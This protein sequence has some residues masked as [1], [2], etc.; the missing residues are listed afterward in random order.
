MTSYTARL[1]L[2]HKSGYALEYHWP[3]F[4]PETFINLGYIIHKP[5]R[6]A[7]EAESTAKSTTTGREMA[8]I[9]ICDTID[10]EDDS[11]GNIEEEISKI[12]LP[13]KRI[14]Y[15]QIILIEGVPGIG[16]TMLMME[17][18][19]LWANN[20][21]LENTKVLLLFFL[22]D[23]KINDFDSIKDMFHYLCQIEEHA[24]IYAKYFE[25]N[26]GKGLTILLDGFDENP[27][28]MQ[29]GTFFHKILIN[30]KIFAEACIIITSRPHVTTKLQNYVSYRV[31][32]IGFTKDRRC[33]FVQ[34]NLKEKA[35]DL[36]NYLEDHEIIDTL[37]YIPLNMSIVVSLSKLEV[38]LIDLPNNQTELTRQAVRMTVFHYLEELKLTESQ[39]QNDLEN[40]PKPFNEV[41]YYLTELAYN[42]MAKM[43]LTFTSNE[44]RK[45]CPVPINGNNI[46][47][48]TIT[49]GLGLIHVAQFTNE[50]Y[51]GTGLLS[52]FA[53]YSV[54]ELLAAWYIAFSH[55][56]Y[57]QQL[58]LTCSIRQGMQ[59]WLQFSFQLKVLKTRF[60]KGE[61]IDVWSFYIGLTGGNDF[62][63]KCFLTSNLF[64]CHMPYKSYP[65]LHRISSYMV[66]QEATP[67]DI[68]E[69]MDVVQWKKRD[70][71]NKLRA[72]LLYYYL[73]EAPESEVIQQFDAVVTKDM[74]DISEQVLDQKQDL[75]LLGNILSRPYL[76]KQWK[77]V[78][79][80]YCEIDDKKF[81]ILHD[82]LTRNDGRFKPKIEALLLS[83]NKLKS[84][85]G[86]IA[87]LACRQ[88]ILYLDL[89]NNVLENF[90]SLRRC[91]FLVTLD[92]SNNKLNNEKVAISLIALQFLRKLKYLKLKHNTIH[93]NQDVIDAIGLALCSCNSLE[94]LEL[95]GNDTEFIDKTTLLFSVIK[96]L[97][98]SRS[99]KHYYSKQTD[100]ASAFL[101]ILVHCNKINYQCDM[102]TLRNIIIQSEVIDISCNGLKTED[103]RCLGQ[104]L[105]LLINLKILIIT[106]NKISDDATESLSIGIILCPNLK[107]FKYDEN[108]F[109]ED[110]IM[111]FK[112]IRRLRMTS[113]RQMFKCPPPKIAALLFILNCI[114][115]NEEKVQSSDMVSTIGL[116]LEL[117][118]SHNKPTTL[119]HK[120]TSEDIK[121]LCAVLRWFKLLEV[122]D[123]SNNDI[124]VEAKTLLEMAMIQICT[125]NSIKLIGNPIFD[126][127]PSM[128][129]FDTIINV[130]ENQVQS[131][132]CNQDSPQDIG[133]HPIL[134]I[135]NCL[136][137]FKNP[138]CFKSFDNIT[139]VDV[140]SEA[141]HGVKVLENLTL[142]P[143]LKVLKIN[144]VPCV[145]D[146]GM[147]ELSKYVS[148]NKTLTTLDLSDC[149]LK[150]LEG[151]LNDGTSNRIPMEVLKLNNSN[152]TVKVLSKLFN[153]ITLTKLNQLELEGNCFGHEGIIIL[154]NKLRCQNDQANVT[155]TIL[156]LAGNQLTTNSAIIIVEMMAT[157]QVKH[158]NISNNDLGNILPHFK[159]F[160][161]TT[162][163]ELNI[164]ANN[165]Q[166]GSAGAF[167]KSLSYLNPCSSLKKLNISSNNIDKT[168]ENEIL[169]FFMKCSHFEEVICTGNPAENEINLAFHH[170]KNRCV[171]HISFK[172]HPILAQDLISNLAL[173]SN[174]QIG[175]LTTS[176]KVHINHVISIDFSHNY[177]KIDKDF[178]CLLQNCF[179]LE[180]LNLE[181]NDIT[182][183][184]FKYYLATGII[185]T[186]KLLL[187]KLQLSGNPCMVVDKLKN[188][189]ILQIIHALRSKSIHYRPPSFEQFLTV[190]ELVDRVNEKQNDIIKHISL[191]KH[192]DIGYSKQLSD[193][194]N[195]NQKL[196]SCDIK[197]ICKYL[198]YFKSLKSIGMTDNNIEKDATDDLAIAILKHS[199]IE[200]ILLKGN[201][202]YK[203]SKCNTLLDT[204]K[205]MRTCGKSYALKRGL[206]FESLEVLVTILQYINSIDDTI[207]YITDSIEQLNVSCFYQP[208]YKLQF[209]IEK[210]EE[211]SIALIC[212]LKLF[213]KLKVLNLS[214][215]YLTANGLQELSRFL[216][217]NNTLLELDISYNDIQVEGALIVLKSLDKNKP[218]TKLKLACNKITGEQCDEMATIICNLR[219]K[220]DVSGNK[221]TEN[222]KK[223]LGLK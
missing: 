222:S 219:I 127:K 99:N 38:Q 178:V 27:Q 177:M 162:L 24:E 54:Q 141:D 71:K 49:N 13:V 30:E 124:T 165:H 1:K 46:I 216:Q 94:V 21:I 131:I 175:A 87:N 166:T 110:S 58:P 168:A 7:E 100:K 120:L 85:S 10:Y 126:D 156:N 102:C 204:I 155:I 195:V 174:D 215:I 148:Q 201:P 212:H 57:F 211:M 98:N 19:R 185:F 42:A 199:N 41:F 84:C 86:A 109:S 11:D 106:K 149:N 217:N 213:S 18:R 203:T 79:L 112:M 2:R 108:L 208:Q 129:V 91:D 53:H 67:N 179:Q 93:G 5:K 145:T 73:Q 105:P 35:E 104:H 26:N 221:L 192:L 152:V 134:Y 28:A 9:H 161:I 116:I 198:K 218:L 200:E 52:N 95:D 172:Q 163:E 207:H 151:E 153:M 14:Q 64:S 121:K 25:R 56:S 196:Q 50:G 135:M 173:S 70:L 4:I 160:T 176:V 107:Q 81:K 138:T 77:S 186:S 61:Y 142:L 206:E 88:Q 159:N 40:L 43:K 97:R 180:A 33:E 113:P 123:V 136:S 191:I 182:N 187:S 220:A 130:R 55:R 23:P 214:R 114:N 69:L 158:L 188:E 205:K 31:E 147:N 68:P 157:Y 47:K 181:Y 137:Q 133:Y 39:N 17:I 74:L 111:I 193:S 75:H 184:A 154:H 12:F 29:S 65:R 63:F 209:G 32:I 80:S 223:I 66:L 34:E 164:S 51:G 146:R 197:N 78:N 194:K 72:L 139:T 125:L 59:N 189:R 62:A 60:W 103:G 115:D 16:K 210:I 128:T 90:S 20:Q 22:R 122:L 169:L 6:T 101:E 167:I 76:T 190:L 118:L 3:P 48:R 202:I 8:P 89:S 171:K 96:E 44:I 170:V 92:I 117:N 132:V 37:C 83:G 150:N 45:A 82:V 144:N 183:E 15:P 36:L 119:D 140:N 143:F